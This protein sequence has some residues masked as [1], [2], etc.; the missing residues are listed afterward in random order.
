MKN[1]FFKCWLSTWQSPK[2]GLAD[3]SS[4]TA[5]TLPFWQAFISGD[6]PSWQEEMNKKKQ[7]RKWVKYKTNASITVGDLFLTFL[8]VSGLAPARSRSLM[9]CSEP[10]CD[11]IHNG[12]APSIRRMLTISS[13]VPSWEA[14]ASRI[15]ATTLACPFWAARNRQVAPSCT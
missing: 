2:E 15:K 6:T 11:A 13:A 4:F 8:H 1:K 9:T 12:V 7:Y 14:A 3:N 5:S 10:N